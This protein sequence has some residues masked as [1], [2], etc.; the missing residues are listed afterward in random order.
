MGQDKGLMDFNGE[1]LILN[2][3]KTVNNSVDEVLLIFR[4]DIQLKKYKN[5]LKDFISTESFNPDLRF[6][7]DEIKGKG[8]LAGI[9]VGLLNINNEY[10]LILPCDSPFVS[11]FFINS[12]FGK[13]QHYHKDYDSIV[14]KWENGTLEPLHAIYKAKTK[15]IIYKMISNDKR[16]VKSF[17]GEINPLFVASE[18]LDPSGMSFK[19]FNRPEDIIL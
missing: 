14:P 13:I 12:I 19:N 17:I 7:V 1:P 8:P 2:I 9:L 10:A 18:I 3:L 15:N 5:I 4:D 11:E 16:D 6:F